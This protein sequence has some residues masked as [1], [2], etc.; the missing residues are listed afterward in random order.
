MALAILLR[1][2]LFGLAGTSLT[3]ARSTLPRSRVVR[4]VATEPA[5][6]S[7]AVARDPASHP[8]FELVRVEMVDEYRARHDQNRRARDRPRMP[9]RTAPLR[10]LPGDAV[11]LATVPSHP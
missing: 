1:G 9:R 5:L 11:H 7:A 2:A 6:A 3:A 4:G 10:H 8:A